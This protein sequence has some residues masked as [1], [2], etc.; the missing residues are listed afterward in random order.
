MGSVMLA[1]MLPVQQAFQ[2]PQY[3]AHSRSLPAVDLINPLVGESIPWAS[4]SLTRLFE[5]SLD[6]PEKPSFDIAPAF[7]PNTVEKL[8]M[9]SNFAFG[10]TLL[11]LGVTQKLPHFLTA[12]SPLI[13][14]PVR[15]LAGYA[16]ASPLVGPGGKRRNAL[17]VFGGN[18]LGALAPL[19][20]LSNSR[21]IFSKTLIASSFVFMMDRLFIVGN[22]SWSVVHRLLGSDWDKASRQR[23]VKTIL[24][25]LLY[26]SGIFTS[27]VLTGA[28]LGSMQQKIAWHALLKTSV[29]TSVYP[30]SIGATVFASF[31]QPRGNHSLLFRSRYLIA[32]LL[33]ALVVILST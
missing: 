28:A 33:T 6:Y 19:M 14:S 26:S 3:F 25:I 24:P 18:L 11:T 8:M 27:S 32:S 13:A 7:N 5:S 23:A 9:A 29:M 15:S 20:L 2:P 4:V 16:S 21:L 12:S 30:L 17:Y 22:N 1:G 10:M 31:S